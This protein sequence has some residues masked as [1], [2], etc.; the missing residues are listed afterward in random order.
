MASLRIRGRAAVKY[1]SF[2]RALG[3]NIRRV[4]AFKAAC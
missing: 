1:V 4:A 2:L 3:Q